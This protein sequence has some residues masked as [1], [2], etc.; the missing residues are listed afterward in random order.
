MARDNLL[1]KF[2]RK[3]IF[4]LL[5]LLAKTLTLVLMLLPLIPLYLYGM[6]INVIGTTIISWGS[7]M[8][9]SFVF[10]ALFNEK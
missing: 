10:D 7:A 9:L 6:G 3:L 1:A 8:I 5:K 4:K 2:L